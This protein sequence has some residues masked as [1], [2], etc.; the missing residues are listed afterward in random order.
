MSY[1]DLRLCV[2]VVINMVKSQG[3]GWGWDWDWDWDSIHITLHLTWI[4]IPCFLLIMAGFSLISIEVPLTFLACS[5]HSVHVR[6]RIGNRSLSTAVSLMASLIFPRLLFWYIYPSYQPPFSLLL[7]FSTF[8]VPYKLSS[9]PIRF[10]IFSSVLQ[11]LESMN[12]MPN[13]IQKLI[14]KPS[15]CSQSPS[16]IHDFKCFVFQ[17]RVC[18]CF[19]GMLWENKC[20]LENYRIVVS[21]FPFFVCLFVFLVFLEALYVVM[22][23]MVLMFVCLILMIVGCDNYRSSSL[24]KIMIGLPV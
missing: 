8:F 22:S 6:L 14:L 11:L 5:L 10:M 17:H 21:Q 16:P 12:H 1:F 4:N 7:A 18:M 19:C 20:Y 3:W 13:K 2:P 9:P 24:F 15:E 23:F